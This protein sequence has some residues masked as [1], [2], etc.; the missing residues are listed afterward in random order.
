ML[1]F[2]A[3]FVIAVAFLLLIAGLFRN[4]VSVLAVTHLKPSCKS[5]RIDVLFLVVIGFFWLYAV[6]VTDSYD[7]SNYRYAYVFRIAHSKEMLFDMIQF[8]FHDAGW[9]FD[10]FK[11]L[12]VTIVSL[13]L[14]SGIRNYS[15]APGVVAALALVTVLTAFITQMRSAMVEAVFLNAFPLLYS[16]KKRDRFLYLGIIL[17]CTQIHLISCA[18][19]P[20]FFLRT[21]E[22]VR[23][24][25]AF[26][27]IV[28]VLTIL[29]VFSSS[30]AYITISRLLTMLPM[31]SDS[32]NRI[33]GYFNGEGTHFR[34]AV[35]LICKHLLMFFL[36]DQACSFQLSYVTSEK[37]KRELK[38]IRK[39]N[40]L[41]LAFLPIT[42]LSA[43]F[44]RLFSCFAII[45]Y[46]MVFSAGKQ[47]LALRKNT[48]LKQSLQSVMVIGMLMITFVELYFSSSDLVRVLNSIQWVF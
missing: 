13:L 47:R 25:K 40:T 2:K 37:D 36:T 19:L 34:Y 22:N 48:Y 26:Y 3:V 8:F 7:I 42:V 32:L 30:I 11:L 20:F 28:A 17:L 44:E 35:F 4:S 18:F 12:W 16:G 46:A 39:A 23:I 41:M 9:S 27:V 10:S 45:Q 31:A 29:A 33:L 5:K 24:K 6:L 1:T 15:R 21:K 43:S 38:M 14:Y